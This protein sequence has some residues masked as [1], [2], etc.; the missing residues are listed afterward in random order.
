MKKIKIIPRGKFILVIPELESSRVSEH[1]IV[2]PDNVEQETKAFGTVKAFGPEVENIKVG[3]KC[4]Y[5]VFAGEKISFADDPKKIEYILVHD[6]DVFA[7]LEY[8]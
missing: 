7:G 6:D 2:T 4:I 8:E 5:G 1:G 3:D